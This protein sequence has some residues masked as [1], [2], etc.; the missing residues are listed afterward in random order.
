MLYRKMDD[1]LVLNDGPIRI[2]KII[3]AFIKLFYSGT[4]TRSFLIVKTAMR[5]LPVFSVISEIVR[6]HSTT[7]STFQKLIE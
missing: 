5:N 3:S 7:Q 4:D 1:F 2:P 6:K